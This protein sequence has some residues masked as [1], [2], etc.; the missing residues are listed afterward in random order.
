MPGRRLLARATSRLAG[1]F[2]GHCAPQLIPGPELAPEI[3]APA[4]GYVAGRHAAH[5][6][7]VGTDGRPRETTGD[8]NRYVTRRR[9]TVAEWPRSPAVG[10][11]RRSHPTCEC[12]SGADGGERE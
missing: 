12:I 4:V 2:H 6:V 9:R 11:S 8:L 5:V 7:V 3:A 1:D 10:R